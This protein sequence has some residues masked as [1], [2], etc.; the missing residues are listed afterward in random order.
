MRLRS[1]K[2]PRNIARIISYILEVSTKAFT[3]SCTRNTFP[4]SSITPIDETI[5]VMYAVGRSI[6]S[7]LRETSMGGMAV[8]K[9]AC[10]ACA[11]CAKETQ[12]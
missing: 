5:G 9:S 6:P 2:Q 8:A 11:A 4:P 3:T 10:E 12:K 1:K 7:E